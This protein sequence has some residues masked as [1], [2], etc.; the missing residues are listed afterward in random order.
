MPSAPHVFTYLVEG[1]LRSVWTGNYCS[2]DSNFQKLNP[3]S[4][5]EIH[6]CRI[7]HRYRRG[8]GGGSKAA[9]LLS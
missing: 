3:L 8:D 4:I 9:A 2:K 6:L 1:G 5:V 7:L